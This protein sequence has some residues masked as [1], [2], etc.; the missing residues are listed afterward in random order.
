LTHTYPIITFFTEKILFNCFLNQNSIFMSRRISD[1]YMPCLVSEANGLF[2]VSPL[3]K[4][5]VYYIRLRCS[6]SL[7]TSPLASPLS[8]RHAGARRCGAPAPATRGAYGHGGSPSEPLLDAIR[9]HQQ[10]RCLLQRA[11]PEVAQGLGAPHRRRH[12]RVRGRE[13]TRWQ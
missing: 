10:Q 3:K 4:S 6:P 13:L 1:Q 2:R 8:L 12:R 9:A 5:L 7:A 11:R